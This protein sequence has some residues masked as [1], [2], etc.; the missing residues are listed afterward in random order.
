MAFF[1]SNHYIGLISGT[2]ADAIDA[3]LVNASSEGF[4]LLASHAH[5]LPDDY[6]Q[7]VLDL[8]QSAQPVY[9]WQIAR[10]DQE[11]AEL[12]AQ[13]VQ[14]LLQKAEMSA[15]Q[16]QA[17]GSHGQTLYH[18]APQQ[19]QAGQVPFT[20]QIGDPNR[21]AYRT[22]IPVVADFRRKDMAAGGQGAPLVPAFHYAQFRH[23][24]ENRIVLNTGG[25]ANITVLPADTQQAVLG[26]DTGPANCLM[27][28]WILRHKALS[29]DENGA[30]AAT[31]QVLPVLLERCLNDPYFALAPPK[32]TGRDYFNLSWLAPHLEGL[33][34][35]PQ[36]VQATLLQ[37]TIETVIQAIQPYSA[38]RL[39]VCGGGAYNAHFMQQLQTQLPHLSVESTEHQGLSPAWVEACCFAW[40]AQQ[41]L[42]AQPGNLPSV[43]GAAQALV[44]GGLYL[45][46]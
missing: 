33:E 41:R 17:I 16:I 39:L 25:I 5:P 45:P 6:H 14:A 19:T 4:Q 40:L 3:V 11:T 1:M 36:N 32:S 23:P 34:W 9:P 46:A 38:H 31:G 15:T 10:L 30:W 2:S 42:Q 27:D 8:S 28:A 37:L 35:T 13:A 43:T 7:T 29:M 18:L 20:W 22:G 44:L 24:K 21:L 12:F 26:F